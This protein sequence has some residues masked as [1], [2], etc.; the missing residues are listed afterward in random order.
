MAERTRKFNEDILDYS[1]DWGRKWLAEGDYITDSTW[2]I[3]GGD[4]LTP[5]DPDTRPTMAAPAIIDANRNSLVWILNGTPGQRYEVTNSI[6][7]FHG[8]TVSDT[9]TLILKD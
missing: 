2:T 4:M 6:V 3:T 9:F 8:R 7:T 5:P 1:F